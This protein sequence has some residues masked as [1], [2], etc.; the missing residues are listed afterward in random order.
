MPSGTYHNP[1]IKHLF[2]V[3]TGVDANG[4]VILASISSWKNDLCDPTCKLSAGCHEFVTKD[5]YILYRKSRIEKAETIENGIKT[6]V[7][8]QKE[9]ADNGLIE[10]ALQGFQASN[11][12][13]KKIK[14]YV[15]AILG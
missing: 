14:R 4:D 15:K 12:T 11:Q 8:I 2:F 9:D 13:P 5:S 7:F 1:E 3:C 6:G 10:D